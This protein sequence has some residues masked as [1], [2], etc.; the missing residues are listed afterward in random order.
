MCNVCFVVPSIMQCGLVKSV[1]IYFE[2]GELLPRPKRSSTNR[3]I[4]V[5]SPTSDPNAN[6]TYVDLHNYTHHSFHLS[7]L[8]WCH[9]SLE[10][11]FSEPELQVLISGVDEE[12]NLVDLKAHTAFEGGYTNADPTVNSDC[13]WRST[14]KV[15][16]TFVK[17]WQSRYNDSGD[18]CAS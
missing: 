10:G 2:S 17:F 11:I 3:G 4:S 5:R 9:P 1:P 8:D 7:R 15:P 16:L 12:L 13:I 6:I 14:K 18:V